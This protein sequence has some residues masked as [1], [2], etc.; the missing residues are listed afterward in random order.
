ML[1]RS[2]R[3]LRCLARPKGPALH[4][5]DLIDRR[6]E[7]VVLAGRLMPGDS[8]RVGDLREVTDLV[9]QDVRGQLPAQHRHRRATAQRERDRLIDTL[10]RR[11]SSRSGEGCRECDRR[12][13]T[14][15]SSRR[16]GAP[17]CSG[18]GAPSSRDEMSFLDPEHVIE[19]AP[20][21]REPGAA[22]KRNRQTRR[23]GGEPRLPFRPLVIGVRD[24]V[25]EFDIRAHGP[26]ASS[27]DIT[28]TGPRF[29]ARMPGSMTLR[30]PTTTT[31]KR[32]GWM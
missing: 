27:T 17:S 7:V 2:L 3:L 23:V 6:E 32:F 19:Q 21:G 14:A 8:N 4:A 13:R 1:I 22:L 24:Q 16:A 31:A 28:R 15:P 26:T 18:T 30:S 10:A 9:Q 5:G 11:A 20:D 12:I 25:L 29:S